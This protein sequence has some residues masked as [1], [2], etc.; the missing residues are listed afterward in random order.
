VRSINSELMASLPLR[1]WSKASS[2]LWVK[3]P[4]L[5]AEHGPGALMCA[6]REDT[7]DQL[8]IS[9]FL[10]QLSRA[11]QGHHIS[12]LFTEL[13]LNWSA[14]FRLVEAWPMNPFA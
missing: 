14:L 9:A 7:A 12:R 5:K 3:P 1:T 11:A 2:R 4:A 6:R 10:V 13:C 8:H